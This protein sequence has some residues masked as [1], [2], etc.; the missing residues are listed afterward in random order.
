MTTRSISSQSYMVIA[1]IGK[2]LH[3]FETVLVFSTSEYHHMK[4]Y[5]AFWRNL[6]FGKN[7]IFWDFSEFL[8]IQQIGRK[9]PKIIKML[10]FM[11]K[12]VLWITKHILHTWG[13]N[14]KWAIWKPQKKSF[15][16]MRQGIITRN[17]KN[18]IKP[19]LKVQNVYFPNML[20]T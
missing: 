10:L 14:L 18:I 12:H 13:G 5:E 6:I 4:A 7:R 1:C 19:I 9:W 16:K 17:D 2:K 11:Q 3:A 20:F 15:Y 8:M